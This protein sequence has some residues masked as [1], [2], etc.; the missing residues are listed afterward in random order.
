MPAQNALKDYLS[1]FS[2][3]GPLPL[4]ESYKRSSQR[5]SLSHQLAIALMLNLLSLAMPIMILQ[6]YDRI[7]PHQSY[8]TL[9]MLIAGVLIA[10]SLDATL[11]IMRA[12]LVGWSAASEEHA[13]ACAA[14]DH[15]L[16]ADLPSFDKKSAG[17]HLQ[18][19]GALNR[20]REFYSGQAM[21][22]LIDFP[23]AGLF[24]L[25]IAYL[26]GVLV[27][28]PLT[29][30][31]VF[32]IC[33]IY[34]GRR[35]KTALEHRG[36]A[37]DA[38]ASFV[39]SVLG[40]IHTAK[41]FAI[42]APLLRRFENYQD[43]VTQDSYRVAMA[44]GLAGNLSA[45][46]GQL[47][48]ILT[49]GFGCLL[50]LHG[51]L[52]V[53]GLS[54]CTLLAGRAIQPVQRVLGTWLRLQDMSLARSHAAEIF[55]LPAPPRVA[56]APGF[57]PQGRV[58]I[59]R[60][61]Y[62]YQD[63]TQVL[64]EISLNIEAGEVV[65]IGGDKASGKS[66]LLQLAAG[67]LPTQSGTV[68]VDD[69]DPALLGLSRLR[70]RIGYLPQQGTIFRGTILENMTG[71]RNDEESIQR[72]KE[73]GAALGLDSVVDLLPRGYQTLLADTAADP[74]PP[75]I[76]QRI[77]LVRVLMDNPALLLFDDADRA[78]DKEGYNR[79][80]RLIGRMKGRCTILMVSHD[81]NL[82]SFADRRFVLQNGRLLPEF[83]HNAS[84]I[85]YLGMRGLHD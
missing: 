74:V 9:V 1:M 29:L 42:E 58:I 38:K 67:I 5:I 22:A 20:L 61:S 40:G 7:I 18:N 60:A 77:S 27:L 45:A 65:A 78:L 39:V 53:G 16:H 28:V 55:D 25:L 37:D 72:A 79:L 81:Q 50:V 66:T 41:S 10:L 84:N 62:S 30:L 68:R 43:V 59:D 26:G 13:A 54:A 12:W 15:I 83:T 6:V 70:G 85:S 69:I 35:L 51:G 56:P 63:G 52:S 57:S 24:L 75:G 80:F 44:S 48:L 64:K 21:T 11:R 4:P 34:A 73:T 31:A 47:S 32:F 2:T 76:K 82:L 49:A 19:L 46:F 36:A 8:G 71:F 33:A 3:R 23:F 14:V 17:E